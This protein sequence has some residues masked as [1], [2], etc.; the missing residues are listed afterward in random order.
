MNICFKKG[1][2]VKSIYCQ[3][4]I[5]YEG[6]SFEIKRYMSSRV[7]QYS[8]KSMNQC[9]I[10]MCHYVWYNNTLSGVSEFSHHIYYSK[11]ASEIYKG[12]SEKYKVKSKLEPFSG[13]SPKN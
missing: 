8:L 5:K 1:K 4:R 7:S 13:F 9:A 12:N 3:I 2:S 11:I 6:E 10:K